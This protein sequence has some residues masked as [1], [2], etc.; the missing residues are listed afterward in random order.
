MTRFADALHICGQMSPTENRSS[1]AHRL[2]EAV[3]FAIQPIRQSFAVWKAATEAAPPIGAPKTKDA[4][5]APS[6]QPQGVR[7]RGRHTTRTRKHSNATLLD[8]QKTPVGG[9][10]ARVPTKGPRYGRTALLR[11]LCAGRDD[12]DRDNYDERNRRNDE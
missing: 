4:L 11:S 3:R 2:R 10:E 6:F 1:R 12:S 8:R 9:A 5:K 7:D